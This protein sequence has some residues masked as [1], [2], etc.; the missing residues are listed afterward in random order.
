MFASLALLDP[1]HS[2]LLSTVLIYLLTLYPLLTLI[3]TSSALLTGLALTRL[4]G[5][6]S[7]LGA[8]LFRAGT[9]LVHFVLG[10][11]KHLLESPSLA[12]RWRRR[13]RG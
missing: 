8:H 9:V 12:Q 3:S 5:L 11:V 7:H 13:S 2:F 1:L 4:G 6:L 10:Y